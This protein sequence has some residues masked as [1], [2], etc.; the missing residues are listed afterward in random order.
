MSY[1]T[2]ADHDGETPVP[3]L[4]DPPV[5]AWRVEDTL[6]SG[7]LTKYARD[8]EHAH[9]S[10]V[11]VSDVLWT[12]DTS[13]GRNPDELVMIR[14]DV[15]TTDYDD[16]DYATVIVTVRDDEHGDDVASYRLDGRA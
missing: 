8:L 14:P 5:Y 6:T 16:N 2:T 12:V 15:H 10:D 11:W 4:I 3:E 1:P 9:H 13:D 7:T